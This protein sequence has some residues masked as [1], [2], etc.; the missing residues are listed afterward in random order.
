RFTNRKS[1]TVR[2][3]GEVLGE[4]EKQ[5]NVQPSEDQ[6]G[7]YEF[8]GYN[9]VLRYANGVVYHLPTFT[10]DADFKQIWFRGGVLSQN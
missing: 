4:A 8:D 7:H 2:V 6:R 5:S 3:N 1:E 10:L 9:L